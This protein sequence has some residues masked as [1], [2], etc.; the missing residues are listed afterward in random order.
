MGLELG[1]NDY[2]TKPFSL[3]VLRAC[4]GVQLRGGIQDNGAGI[5]QTD[6]FY[7]DFDKMNYQVDGV[8]IELSRTEQKLLR[9]FIENRGAT[10]R[11]SQIIDHVWSG[12]TEYVEEHALTVA[13]KRLRDKMEIDSAHP[14]CIKTVYG[15]GYTW[16]I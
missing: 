12:E 13:I 14:Q 8:D 6:R 1:A 3:A 16:E 5:F 7:F 11:R 10:L 9:L 15:I 2:I 4:A